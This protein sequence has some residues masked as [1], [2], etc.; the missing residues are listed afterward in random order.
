MEN[1]ISISN[2]PI[3][4]Q[5][6]VDKNTFNQSFFDK[7]T[8]DE[9]LFD[10]SLLD[11]S[12]FDKMTI[13]NQEEGTDWSQNVQMKKPKTFSDLFNHETSTRTKTI[14]QEEPDFESN[15]PKLDQD[16]IILY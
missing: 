16:Q 8:F 7:N 6:L 3:F 12:M 1:P 15:S 2:Q 13:S 10:Q 11:K 5:S 4:D 14:D 9:S